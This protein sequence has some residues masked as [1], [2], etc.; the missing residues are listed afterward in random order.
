MVDVPV[1]VLGCKEIW[2]VKDLVFDQGVRNSSGQ[3]VYSRSPGSGRGPHWGGFG[4]MNPAW[5]IKVG[6]ALYWQ[7]GLG[8]LYRINLEGDF[9]PNKVSWTGISAEGGHWSF[10]APAVV[11][12]EIYI[13]S[14]LELV[15]LEWE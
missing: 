6:N 12:N 9:S 15:R 13:R 2:D 3:V 7:G 5:P 11:G 4:H 8:V 10:G 1:Q 14:Q